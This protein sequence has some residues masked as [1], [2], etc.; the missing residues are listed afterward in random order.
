MRR[1]KSAVARMDPPAKTAKSDMP[2]SS[3]V[4]APLRSVDRAGA[5]KGAGA[6]EAAVGAGATA[7]G[8]VVVVVVVV[9]CSGA[10]G[11]GGGGSTDAVTGGGG[12]GDAAARGGVA[13]IAD[14]GRLRFQP[15]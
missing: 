11:S 14:T 6:V 15:E 9:G 3:A 4:S 7:T 1:A 10:G 8:S 12:A 2:P 5:A 13:D